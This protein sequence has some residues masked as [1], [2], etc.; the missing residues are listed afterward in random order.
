MVSR[1]TQLLNYLFK[2]E[3]L[4]W[5]PFEN[6]HEGKSKCFKYCRPEFDGALFYKMK[7]TY[8][9]SDMTYFV[10]MDIY[11]SIYNVLGGETFIS[12]ST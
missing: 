3:H 4:R 9:V 1:L 6:V 12:C 2:F 11:F 7:E 8:F 10:V 5:E